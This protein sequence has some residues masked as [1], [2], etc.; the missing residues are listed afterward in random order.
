MERTDT[1]DDRSAG[2]ATP[3]RSGATLV[4]CVCLCVGVLRRFAS[5]SGSLRS[6]GQHTHTPGLPRSFAGEIYL[7]NYNNSEFRLKL[8]TFREFGSYNADTQM[9][10]M[11]EVYYSYRPAGIVRWCAL[12]LNQTHVHVPA[13]SHSRARKQNT[14]AEHKKAQA[15]RTGHVHKINLFL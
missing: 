2:S 1:T 12:A 8:Y 7:N 9:S 3:V 6:G 13:G 14:R 15:D 10:G 11:L 5:L 4:W